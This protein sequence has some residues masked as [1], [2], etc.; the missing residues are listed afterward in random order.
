MQFEGGYDE[1]P[2]NH[3]LLCI[4]SII[5]WVIALVVFMIKKSPASA[6]C[7]LLNL[8]GTLLWVFSLSGNGLLPPKGNWCERIAWFFQ[9]TKGRT[10]TINPR[11]LF[12]GIF[13]LLLSAVL[14]AVTSTVGG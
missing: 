6:I 14:Q 12:F 2:L 7:L 5:S 8:Q 9:P 11:K 4:F 13:L 1:R 10:V 3:R